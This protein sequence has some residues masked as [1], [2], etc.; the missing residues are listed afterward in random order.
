[1]RNSFDATYLQETFEK[2]V[3]TWK[4]ALNTGA[5]LISKHSKKFRNA[6]L[7]VLL[8]TG[9]AN[10]IAQDNWPRTDKQLLEWTPSLTLWD[11]KD[12]SIL[13]NENHREVYSEEQ[14][15]ASSEEAP[16]Y[17]ESEARRILLKN[18]KNEDIF[19]DVAEATGA[20]FS[21]K[22]MLK[23]ESFQDFIAMKAYKIQV[24]NDLQWKD[25][26]VG[27][28]TLK[29]FAELNAS[30]SVE[31]IDTTTIVAEVAETNDEA[32]VVL[33]TVPTYI[34]EAREKL[35]KYHGLIEENYHLISEILSLDFPF[36]D[37][38]NG[39]QEDNTIIAILKFQKKYNL[40][41]ASVIKLD[42]DG[43]LWTQTFKSMKNSDITLKRYE[44]FTEKTTEEI[45]IIKETPV[46]EDTTEVQNTQVISK[47]EIERYI[48]SICN[49]S[50]LTDQYWKQVLEHNEL[51]KCSSEVR[52]AFQSV[53]DLWDAINNLAHDFPQS[54][55][56]AEFNTEKTLSDLVQNNTMKKFVK[57]KHTPWYAN[58]H[59]N[60]SEHDRID[61]MEEWTFDFNN[62]KF[63]AYILNIVTEQSKNSPLILSVIDFMWDKILMWA[64]D[65][66]GN[67]EFDRAS[68]K[69]L[70][71]SWSLRNHLIK[72][73]NRIG[74]N[75]EMH[76]YRN[77]EAGE[78]LFTWVHNTTDYTS[79]VTL[80]NY[81]NQG[82]TTESLKKEAK[83]TK[84]DEQEM[85]IELYKKAYNSKNLFK[86]F[87]WWRISDSEA[88]ENIKKAQ[89]NTWI[90]YHD[91]HYARALENLDE[92]KRVRVRDYLTTISYI[93]G[94]DVSI[95]RASNS[96]SEGSEKYTA[97]DIN[98]LQQKTTAGIET[99]IDRVWD[100]DGE[101][102]LISE[103]TYRVVETSEE[104]HFMTEALVAPV[105]AIDNDTN[106]SN[107][108]S[109][110]AIWSLL[111]EQEANHGETGDW[112]IPGLNISNNE[113]TRITN[114]VTEGG[115]INQIHSIR[116]TQDNIPYIIFINGTTVTWIKEVNGVIQ[117]LSVIEYLKRSQEFKF[118]IGSE[119]SYQH[120][121]FSTRIEDSFNT[122]LDAEIR[123]EI[124]KA[125][126]SINWYETAI[127]LFAEG[128][129]TGEEKLGITW[130]IL[131]FNLSKDLTNGKSYISREIAHIHIWG[132]KI[133]ISA[134]WDNH[135]G[136]GIR[137]T[138]ET[139]YDAKKLVKK[140]DKAKQKVLSDDSFQTKI[141][142]SIDAYCK[143][144][145]FD[146]EDLDIGI[147][148]SALAE[149][150]AGRNLESDLTIDGFAS[151]G[152]NRDNLL[153]NFALTNIWLKLSFKDYVQVFYL[154]EKVTN[155][156]TYKLPIQ[157][158][159][160]EVP[161]A[162]GLQY[163]TKADLDDFIYSLDYPS[164]NIKFKGPVLHSEKV[165]FSWEL[166][167]SLSESRREVVITAERI[168][169][170]SFRQGLVK[171][172]NT[173]FMWDITEIEKHFSALSQSYNPKVDWE[174]YEYLRQNNS[175]L[176]LLFGS[177]VNNFEVML[178]ASEKIYGEMWTRNK[179]E[180]EKVNAGWLESHKSWRMQKLS[181]CKDTFET[182]SKVYG[183]DLDMSCVIPE[184]V[185]EIKSTTSID[186]TVTSHTFENNMEG[187]IQGIYG[188]VP[189]TIEAWTDF[190]TLW[191]VVEIADWVFEGQAKK[192]GNYF[193][194]GN[195]DAVSMN[196]LTTNATVEKLS[197][198]P[199]QAIEEKTTLLSA[200]I[201]LNVAPKTIKTIREITDHV[202][203][204]YTETQL[205][206]EIHGTVW[207]GEGDANALRVQPA[208]E[209][210]NPDLLN[211]N[212]QAT[213]EAGIFESNQDL[214]PEQSNVI[215]GVVFDNMQVGPNFAG[216]NTEII[217]HPNNPLLTAHEAANQVNFQ[218]HGWIDN[219][220]SEYGITAE[221]TDFWYLDGD[222]FSSATWDA[223]RDFGRED[224]DLSRFHGNTFINTHVTSHSTHTDHNV[225]QT[226]TNSKTIE[227]KNRDHDF[228]DDYELDT[229]NINNPDINLGSQTSNTRIGIIGRVKAIFGTPPQDVDTCEE[230]RRCFSIA[231]LDEIGKSVDLRHK[232]DPILNSFK[233]AKTPDPYDL[234]L[235]F[236][237]V[238]DLNESFDGFDYVEDEFEVISV[239]ER[240]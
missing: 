32:P 161:D 178:A 52:S 87:K 22:E 91:D 38:E 3:N 27:P 210:E 83:I 80:L 237:D 211:P 140:L 120:K 85:L 137:A 159:T 197:Y 100:D 5:Q 192:C 169:S 168:E 222:N 229:T 209:S 10:A 227:S 230:W 6:A 220:G 102:T 208:N 119:T 173:D 175:D 69:E 7:A 214:T 188:P 88:L 79:L 149:I 39:S 127:W 40:L 50:A 92:A 133:A 34:Q 110:S 213:Y 204:G 99:D 182:F 11:A 72:H 96:P 18:V 93:H 136:T 144:Y 75:V 84:I 71:Y 205:S 157:I 86:R 49:R 64:V 59:G 180:I 33:A 225:N 121:N 106:F 28:E 152:I 239:P 147:L 123:A 196:Q 113:Y 145:A 228:Y 77:A 104:G 189:F 60:D 81:F 174:F 101:E 95:V 112:Y 148:V 190:E 30:K 202:K 20:G 98:N 37:I 111:L 234:E 216:W 131:G 53:Q 135:V 134:N 74:G 179:D 8:A 116:L 176:F 198:I 109:T 191:K 150:E 23:N 194:V 48:N 13:A 146:Q 185:E 90:D 200:S 155:V 231:E 46:V 122:D 24:E 47:S 42:E 166:S 44:D 224:S 61:N 114:I 151:F 218:T 139:P 170:R 153:S 217:S 128:D 223:N 138:T 183:E 129:T 17:N 82:G 158:E 19:E 97:N 12:A 35:P 164:D 226:V 199:T 233:I 154:N 55:A 26:Q 65:V 94:S 235:N 57:V 51:R 58:Q 45:T 167:F 73:F 141:Q 143:T 124:L 115:D 62:K 126:R 16:K 78:E 56:G 142:G 21:F 207:G 36:S 132:K 186:S 125:F 221:N 1:M 163:I 76:T 118:K 162:E 232:F 206:W 130:K 67:G 29:T 156:S 107:V 25:G 31:I 54:F 219:N 177:Y 240:I 41:E 181:Q 165:Y 117:T 160:A 236:D 171:D 89:A 15:E 193:I 63:D 105:E 215:W 66:E 43:V 14:S 70:K 201:N 238:E 9:S 195:T 108:S 187:F 68:I 212:R 2:I 172:F 203:Y 184:L 4:N 103:E